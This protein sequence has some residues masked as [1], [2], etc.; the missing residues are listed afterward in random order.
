MILN[1]AFSFLLPFLFLWFP[2]TDTLRLSKPTI[3]IFFS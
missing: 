1:F 2:A 3:F